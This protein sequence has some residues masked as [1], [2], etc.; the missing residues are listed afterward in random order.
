MSKEELLLQKEI[1]QKE[2]DEYANINI[3]NKRASF[4]YEWIERYTAGIV[5]YGEEVKSLQYGSGRI[6]EAFCSFNGS[7][8]YLIN[9]YIGRYKNSVVFNKF[10]E[11]RSRKLLLNKSELK[12]L[13]KAVSQKGLTIIPIR[14]YRNDKG[15]IKVDI[16]LAK[17]K[18]DYDKRES[19]KKRDIE[20]ESNLKF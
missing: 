8:L 12:K 9:S 10:D 20:R 6:T 1:L 19:I 17:G 7:E 14:L 11:V 13:Q 4:D 5:L 3:Q 15:L 2:Y 18:H 16:A